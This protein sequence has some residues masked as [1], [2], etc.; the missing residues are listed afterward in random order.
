MR[1]DAADEKID[2]MDRDQ[3]ASTLELL[4]KVVSKARDDT[5]L[6]NWG[7]IW[8]CSAVSNGVGFEGT[9]YLLTTRHLSPKPYV[10][11]W[12]V[13]FLFN[14]LFIGTLKGRAQGAPSFIEKQVWNIWNTFIGG[15]VLVALVN[16]LLGLSTLLFMPAVASV[17]AAMTFSIMGA[18]MGRAWYVAAGVWAAVSLGMCFAPDHQFAIFGALWSL[19]QFTGGALLHRAKLRSQRTAGAGAGAGTGATT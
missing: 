1:C 12:S 4:R 18:I 5:A 9:H 8:M 2:D 13:V 19:T 11:L 15:M 17:L 10:I 3:A 7:L 14:G 16:Y 6:Q